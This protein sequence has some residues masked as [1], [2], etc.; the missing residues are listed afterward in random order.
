MVSRGL[1][2]VRRCA[3][4]TDQDGGRVS[5]VLIALGFKDG[6]RLHRSQ[7]LTRVWENLSDSGREVHGFVLVAELADLSLAIADLP[8]GYYAVV[9]HCSVG[10]SLVEGASLFSEAAN[11]LR[12]HDGVQRLSGH[13]AEA[14]GFV[15]K[16][17]CQ[18]QSDRDAL[19]TI[20]RRHPRFD[21]LH[22]AL[23]KTLLRPRAA[24]V[25]V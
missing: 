1:F 20:L 18:N 9:D 2:F 3:L 21:P 6:S 19:Q 23:R 12:R 4:K 22:E 14:L 25:L 11:L 10:G 5:D 13:L 16:Q 15:V 7:M 8:N 24:P 17:G